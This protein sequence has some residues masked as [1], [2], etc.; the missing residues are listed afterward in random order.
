MTSNKLQNISVVCTILLFISAIISFI[1]QLI[2]YFIFNIKM[3]LYGINDKTLFS[4]N[5]YNCLMLIV[6]IV[7]LLFIVYLYENVKKNYE[8]SKLR[9]F[10][11]YIFLFFI[12]QILLFSTTTSFYSEY[13]FFVKFI[14]NSIIIFSFVWLYFDFKKKTY[15]QM[16]QEIIDIKSSKNVFFASLIRILVLTICLIISFGLTFGIAEVLKKQY[17]INESY[18]PIVYVGNDYYIII[19]GIYDKKEN[20]YYYIYGDYKLIDKSNINVKKHTYTNLKCKK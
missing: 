6:V 15:P 14:A 1:L 20:T 8:F 18:Q 4:F 11:C 9:K 3:L 5:L 2:C 7:L 12:A 19:N 13:N 17:T 10:L 16:F